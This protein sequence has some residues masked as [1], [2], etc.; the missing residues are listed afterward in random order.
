MEEISVPGAVL[1]IGVYRW[2]G[3]R[4]W[5]ATARTLSMLGAALSSPSASST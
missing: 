3:H 4:V 2:A 1:E 5:G